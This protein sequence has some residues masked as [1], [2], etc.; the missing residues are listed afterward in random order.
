[1]VS[2]ALTAPHRTEKVPV[3][4]PHRGVSKVPALHPT[5]PLPCEITCSED[6]AVMPAQSGLKLGEMMRP[7]RVIVV[8]AAMGPLATSVMRRTLAAPDEGLVWPMVVRTMSKPAARMKSTVESRGSEHELPPPPQVPPPSPPPLVAGGASMAVAGISMPLAEMR[9]PGLSCVVVGL[10]IWNE[11]LMTSCGTI[12]L[13]TRN[14]ACSSL[15][16]AGSPFWQPLSSPLNC[17]LEEANLGFLKKARLSSEASVSLPH[18]ITNLK[19]PEIL[20]V[21]NLRFWSWPVSPEM[22]MMV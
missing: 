21:S 12:D 6:P 19:S 22:V 10:K 17:L 11:I 13:I 5:P 7:A 20:V 1:M 18:P 8:S 3:A 16:R 9:A 15:H 4:L 14:D 2:G